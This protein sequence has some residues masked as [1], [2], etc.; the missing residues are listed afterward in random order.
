MQVNHLSDIWIKP[1][2]IQLLLWKLIRRTSSNPLRCSFSLNY[3]ASQVA[4]RSNFQLSEGKQ[5]SITRSHTAV[6]FVTDV[7]NQRVHRKIE[8]KR[9]ERK[10]QKGIETETKRQEGMVKVE[11]VGGKII[12]S[13]GGRGPT[14]INRSTTREINDHAGINNASTTLP[15]RHFREG[16]NAGRR[17]PV[18]RWKSFNFERAR[19]H[20]NER[21]RARIDRVESNRQRGWFFF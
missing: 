9:E 3:L 1:S 2:V 11:E 16:A 17:R 4:Q 21:D 5:H 19:K 13:C 14:E 10:Q 7:K 8:Q 20:E 18:A 15:R 12:A 6:H